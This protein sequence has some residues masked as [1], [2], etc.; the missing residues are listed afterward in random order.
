[1][2]TIIKLKVNINGPPSFSTV[3]YYFRNFVTSIKLQNMLL[4][5]WTILLEYFVHIYI[6]RVNILV[7]CIHENKT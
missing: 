6:V 1:M 4:Q 5:Y 7:F 3:L 2:K